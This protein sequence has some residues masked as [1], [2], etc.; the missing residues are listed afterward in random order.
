[1]RAAESRI[2]LR[3]GGPVWSPR[4]KIMKTASW[5]LTARALQSPYRSPSISP[6]LYPE[7]ILPVSTF[8]VGSIEHRDAAIPNA[9]EPMPHS[10]GRPL[11]K[12]LISRCQT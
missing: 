5:S 8:T 4:L 9:L 1:M 10:L 11:W 2:E 7:A 3:R 12:L 6:R